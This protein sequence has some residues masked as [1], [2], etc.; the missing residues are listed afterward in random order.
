MKRSGRRRWERLFLLFAAVV[1]VALMHSFAAPMPVGG[2]TTT[3]EPMTAQMTVDAGTGGPVMHGHGDAGDEQAP[4]PM[5]MS[6]ELGH[7]CLAVL[8]A[9][10]LL[11]LAV[12]VALLARRVPDGLRRPDV[13]AGSG[14][15]RPPPRTAVRLAQLCVMRN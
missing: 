13:R 1:G 12:A 6:H 5:P 2:E 14:W 10:L 3:S 7:L 9:A 15:P 11:A 4:M 8:S